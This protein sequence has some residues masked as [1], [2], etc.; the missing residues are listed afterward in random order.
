MPNYV[1]HLHDGPEHPPR[2]E[3]VE[4]AD[5]T[6]ARALAELRLMLSSAFKHVDVERN[7]VELF[8]L[9]RD[10]EGPR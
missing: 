2:R 3:V 10:S 4:A 7:D 6:E 8:R 9:H 5:D 1:F